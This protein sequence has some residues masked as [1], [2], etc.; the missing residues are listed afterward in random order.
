MDK[1]ERI[2]CLYLTFLN[3]S[4]LSFS[5]IREY[6]S[7]AYE[8]EPES[9]RRKFE[10]DKENL[11]DLGMQLITIKPGEYL[12]D[13][14]MSSEFVYYLESEPVKLPEIS[15]STT[16][17]QYLSGLVLGV[18]ANTNSGFLT[19]NEKILLINA[20]QKIFYKNPAGMHSAATENL[21]LALKNLLKNDVSNK[22][23]ELLSV[24]HESLQKKQQLA[25]LYTGKSGTS[26]SRIVNP[27]GLVSR[28]SQWCL[29]GWCTQKQQIR[30][31]YINQMV[32]IQITQKSFSTDPK[33]QIA[34][35]NLHPLSVNS[36]DMIEIVIQYLPDAQDRIT[37]FLNGLPSRFKLQLLDN[38]KIKFFTT[39]LNAFFSYLL[40]HP[41]DICAM[42]P[43]Q[44][45][46]QFIDCIKKIK[47]LN[48]CK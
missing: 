7:G 41:N 12:P 6:L 32:N 25:F 3:N 37:G 47:R 21:P 24:V 38:N 20:A 45:R 29:I 26:S 14:N 48:E 40:T 43:A 18:L 5:R 33:F 27:Y 10:R 23:Q 36:H 34:D 8:G 31:F 17:T 28:Q 44:I 13:G 39:N 30:Y 46:N 42:G 2:A 1:L 35:H 15:L 11:R 9:A 22:D 16:E 19:E 4:G